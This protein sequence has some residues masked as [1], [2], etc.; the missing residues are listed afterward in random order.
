MKSEINSAA[1]IPQAA[2][3]AVCGDVSAM[4]LWRWRVTIP[5]WIFPRRE[6]SE[7]ACIGASRRLLLGCMRGS[8]LMRAPPENA[9]GAPVQRAAAEMETIKPPT[10]SNEALISQLLS[11]RD[12]LDESVLVA[13]EVVSLKLAVRA[14][15]RTAARVTV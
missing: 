14:Q 4:T 7:G 11:A 2:V 6:R 5:I 12:R 8:L 13:V 9:D 3:L 10:N 15:W 1:L